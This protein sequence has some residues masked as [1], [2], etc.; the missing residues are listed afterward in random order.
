MQPGGSLLVAYQVRGK[1]VLV[2]GGGHVAAG[3]LL[4]LL[5]ADAAVHLCCPLTGCCA[6]VVHRLRTIAAPALVHHNS[7]FYPGL[8]DEVQP[9][10]V[11]TAVDSP[12]TSSEIYTLCQARRIPVNVA[13]VP[14]ECDFYFGSVHRD[15][16]LQVMVST[17]GNGPKLANIVRRQI[18]AALP[19]NLGQAITC[20]GVL[21]KR[22]RRIAAAPADAQRRMEWMSAV[23]ERWSL[24]ELCQLGE[25]EMEALLLGYHDGR[26]VTLREIRGDDDDDE[27]DGVDEADEC[28]ESAA[29]D[30]GHDDDGRDGGEGNEREVFEEAFDGSFGWF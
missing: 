17:N 13:D 12:H 22:L 2:V 8:L 29:E 19:A 10:L 25:P 14:P 18:A 4:S 11:L 3:R 5:N 1:P 21:R 30:D 16:P 23:C 27:V 7:A 26:V 24:E 15:G 6:E 9:A 20:V 28:W